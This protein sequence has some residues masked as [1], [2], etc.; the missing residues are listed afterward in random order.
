MAEAQRATLADPNYN[1]PFY[2]AGYELS[3]SGD[4]VRAGTAAVASAA[5]VRDR[6][7]GVGMPS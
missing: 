5:R 7:T 6:F 4:I 2:W 1:A 3:G